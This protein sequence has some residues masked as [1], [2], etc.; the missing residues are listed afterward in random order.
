MLGLYCVLKMY[1]C[2]I[3]NKCSIVILSNGS[4]WLVCDV[5]STHACPTVNEI[6]R[7]T[8]DHRSISEWSR[9]SRSAG[10]RLLGASVHASHFTGQAIRR[11]RFHKNI[12]S[13]LRIAYTNFR[14]KQTDNKDNL[15]A[16]N[17]FC[18][19]LCDAL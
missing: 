8:C 18:S 1:V 7:H 16:K 13:V 6:E 4:K 19:W 9:W 2:F 10:C 12:D 3:G 14:S 17:A 15:E 5:G 11:S